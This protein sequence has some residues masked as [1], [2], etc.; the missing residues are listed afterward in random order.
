MISKNIK[1]YIKRRMNDLGNK[2]IPFLFIINFDITDSYICPIKDIDSKKIKYDVNGFTNCDISK[3]TFPKQFYFKKFNLDFDEYKTAFNKVMYNLRQGNSY[4]ANLTFPT[5]IET[6]LNLED[7][8]N[9]S[10]AK[11]KLYYKNKFVVFSPEIFV[12]IKNKKIFSFP[13]KGT[14]DA[15]IA[16]AENIIINDEKEL[17]EHYTIVDLIRNDLSIISKNVKVDKFRYIDKLN[18]CDKQLLQVSSQISGELYDDYNSAIG[19]IITSMLPAGSITGA[20]K[21]KTVDIIKDAEN[22][23]R[24]FY[25]GIFGIFDG[26]NLDSCVMIRFIEKTDKGFIYK[27]GGGITVNSNLNSEYNELIDKVYVPLNRN[28]KSL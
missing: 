8:F 17:A 26:I 5:K 10:E 12:Q 22:Y 20:P 18:T 16:D 25:T 13:M 3:K 27:S 9:H 6:N 21:K 19:D 7:I 15:S 1:D 14:I 23:D 4:L 24:G 28:N 11:Y 2:K